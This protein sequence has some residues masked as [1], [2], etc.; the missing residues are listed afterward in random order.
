MLSLPSN[1]DT[2]NFRLRS[3]TCYS[4]IEY[5]ECVPDGALG[6]PC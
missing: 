4:A 1:T 5:G 2:R 6:E 3:L